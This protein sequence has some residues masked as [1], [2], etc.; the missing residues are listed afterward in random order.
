MSDAIVMIASGDLRLSANQK[1][2]PTQERVEA[3]VTNA[4]RK[5]GR[6]VE[7][8]HAFD[9]VKQHGFI[10]SQK[11]GMDVFRKIPRTAPLMVVR[12]RLA[13]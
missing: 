2:W 13:V 12:G 5:A 6:N 9:P 1:C 11:Y 3:A 8:G 10:D 7:R 4:V